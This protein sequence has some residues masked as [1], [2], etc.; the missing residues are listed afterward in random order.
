VVETA[1]QKMR[2]RAEEGRTLEQIDR[3]LVGEG[4]TE[5]ERDVLQLLARF[6][7]RGGS[8]A[9]VGTGYWQDID[10]EIGA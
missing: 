8:R 7:V 3:A 2:R 5:L 4:L 6:E 9:R 1:R 10:R